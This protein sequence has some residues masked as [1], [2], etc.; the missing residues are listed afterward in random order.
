MIGSLDSSFSSGAH[1]II[2]QLFR[3]GP[4][5][6]QDKHRLRINFQISDAVQNVS[7]QDSCFSGARSGNYS[8]V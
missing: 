1:Q 5:E 2:A 4:V 8:R 7:D 3:N 6:C